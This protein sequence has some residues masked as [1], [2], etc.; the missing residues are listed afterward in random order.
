L[1]KE[2]TLEKELQRIPVTIKAKKSDE[3]FTSGTKEK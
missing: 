2:N 1:W 3:A